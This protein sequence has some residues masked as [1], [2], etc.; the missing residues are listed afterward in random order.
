MASSV[1][2]MPTNAHAG[3]VVV[4]GSYA[5]ALVVTSERIPIAGETLIGRDFRKTH[6]GKGSDM[7]VQAARLGATV[8][9]IGVIGDDDMGR[10]FVALARD[11]GIGTDHVRV[12]AERA[13][14]VGLIVKDDRGK[15]VI[16]VDIGAN[17]LLDASDIDTA[18]ALIAQAGVVLTQLEIPLEAAIH[19]M[20]VGHAHGAI[21]VFNPAPAIDLRSVDLSAVDVLTPNETEARLAVGRAPSDPIDNATVAAELRATGAR[22]VVMTLGDKGSAIFDESGQEDIAPWAVN[23][24]DSNGAGDSFN[25]AL[26]VALAEGR[27]LAESARFAGLVAGLCCTRWE[28]VPSYHTLA[29]VEQFRAAQLNPRE[30]A[31]A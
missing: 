23:A 6:G 2:K 27:T 28:T 21:T 3:R 30:E 25:A 16:V 22:A 20:S 4:V 29:E 12:C 5:T 17:E 31:L 10:G 8:D 9:Y 15:N 18:E 1:Q 19:A 13:T 14:G 7:A 11:E 26:S 24:V